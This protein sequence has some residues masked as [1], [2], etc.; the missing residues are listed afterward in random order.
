MEEAQKKPTI[1]VDRYVDPT[2]EYTT[3]QLR[4]SE[5]YVRNRQLLGQIGTGALILF[6]VGFNLYGLFAWGNYLVFGRTIFF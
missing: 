3:K 5:W 2:G 1:N 4:L 6:A